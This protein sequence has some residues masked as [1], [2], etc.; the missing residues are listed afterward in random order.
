MVVDTVRFGEVD[1]DENSILQFEDGLYGFEDLKRFAIVNC[2]ETQPIYWLQAVDD[3]E[4][5]LPIIDPFIIKEDYVIDVDD[6]ELESLGHTKE[7]D[8][9][10]YNVVVLPQDITQITVNLVAPIFINISNNKAKQVILGVEQDTSVK[11]PAFTPLMNYYKE[12]EK[13]AGTNKENR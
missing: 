12:A 3:G 7:E 13:N 1:I 10:V 11:Y 9:I 5:S 2:K 8:L 4:I 6:K